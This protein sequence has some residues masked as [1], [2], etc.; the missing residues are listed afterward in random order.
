MS[1]ALTD[2]KLTCVTVIAAVSLTPSLVAL[3]A[4]EPT[5]IPVTRPLASTV[6]TAALSVVQA[7]GCPASTLSLASRTT[8]DS[9]VLPCTTIVANAGLT[10]T[11]ATGRAGV[12]VTE[13]VPLAVPLVA[14]M[15]AL[16]GLTPVTVANDSPAF[17]E[18]S[19]ATVATPTSLLVQAT[20]GLLSKRRH[21]RHGRR[22]AR[23]DD[24]QR[25]RRQT[26]NRRVNGVKARS[27]RRE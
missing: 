7:I 26:V 10:V 25:V 16:P 24:H 17:P 21:Q 11:D 6:A 20:D 14:V 23:D 15:V 12:T 27:Q 8:A 18:L 1:P 2:P 3:T 9:C 19:A 22:R 4:A 5:P 13:A